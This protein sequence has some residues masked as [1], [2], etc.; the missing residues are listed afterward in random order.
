MPQDQRG[1]TNRLIS[2]IAYTPAVEAAQEAPD[3]A[4]SV[5]TPGAWLQPAL[6]RLVFKDKV[7]QIAT[8]PCRER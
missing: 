2:S 1:S 6:H 5:S 8:H 7:Q 4:S 3:F